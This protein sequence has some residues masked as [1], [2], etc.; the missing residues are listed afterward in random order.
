MLTSI[1]ASATIPT[2]VLIADA[3]DKF[4][5][6]DLCGP[7]SALVSDVLIYHEFPRLFPNQGYN[8]LCRKC[9]TDFLLFLN[10]DAEMAYG[11]DA[12]AVSF[13]KKH[14]EVGIGCLFWCDLPSGSPYLQSLDG[15]VYANFGVIRRAA[16]EQWG[17]W[18]T[19]SVYIPELGREEK[20]SFYG[21]D[22]GLC[23]RCIDAGFACV[24]IPGTLVKHHREQDDERHQNMQKHLHDDRNMPP[25]S[26]PGTILRRLWNGD[27]PTLQGYARLREKA[28]KFSYLSAKIDQQGNVRA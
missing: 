27:D 20:L 28:A 23:F 19:R 10:D 4:G 11:L 14:S 21:N 3:S 1:V 25:G 26:L 13:M 16:A 12:I 22:V 18:E 24:G 2:K 5:S 6:G 7:K 9:T 8:Q 17:W 15:I